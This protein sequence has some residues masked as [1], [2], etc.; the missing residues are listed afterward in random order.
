VLSIL[1]SMEVPLGK[2]SSFWSISV[3][4]SH[5]N[6]VKENKSNGRDVCHSTRGGGF[7][8]FPFLEGLRICYPGST[9]II[10]GSALA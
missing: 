10:I 2:S 7:T 6:L 9:I 3:P 1:N 5:R 8:L 4:L